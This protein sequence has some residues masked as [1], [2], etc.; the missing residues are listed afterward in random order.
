MAEAKI[1]I[2]IGQITFLGEGEPS[3]LSEQLDKILDRAESLLGTSKNPIHSPQHP[4][5]FDSSD[6]HLF[7]FQ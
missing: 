2:T 6:H 3:W 1:E 5:K 7:C 4:V